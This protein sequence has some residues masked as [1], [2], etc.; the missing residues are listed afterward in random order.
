M[1]ERCSRLSGSLDNVVNLKSR[2]CLNPPFTNDEDKKV[3]LDNVNYEEVDQ[4]CYLSDML[5]TGGGAE[6]RSISRVVSRW[7]IFRKLSLLLTSRLFSHK[8]K[9]K[10]YAT[11]VRSVMLYASEV[12]LLKESDI[13]RTS[14]ICKWCGGCVMSVLETE[15]HRLGVDDIVDVLHQTRLR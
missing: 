11:C 3:E 7:K 9:G 1:H 8:M 10:L 14:L 5:S 4:F 6:A 13:S 12:W 15:N 2:T